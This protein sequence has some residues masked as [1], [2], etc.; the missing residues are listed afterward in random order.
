MEVRTRHPA[1][2]R[3]LPP[4]PRLSQQRSLQATSPTWRWVIIVT[5]GQGPGICSGDVSSPVVRHHPIRRSETDAT[6]LL[7]HPCSS[8]CIRGYPLRPSATLCVEIPPSK[9]KDAED[10]EGKREM[11]SGKNRGC[12]SFITLGSSRFTC[13][14]LAAGFVGSGSCVHH[15]FRGSPSGLHQSAVV[16]L[17]RRKPASAPMTMNGMTLSPI[18]NRLAQ[19]AAQPVPTTSPHSANS[20][21]PSAVFIRGANA[22]VRKA[23]G[24]VAKKFTMTAYNPSQGIQIGSRTLPHTNSTNRWSLPRVPSPIIEA[25]VAK[26]GTTRIHALK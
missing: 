12:R 8:V 25:A 16:I 5:P 18:F 17:P 22:N 3:Q 11:L 21:R 7:P 23:A 19:K 1:H 9:R 14:S 15:S 13:R 6:V 2:R 26:Q 10:A 20:Q 24:A 4:P